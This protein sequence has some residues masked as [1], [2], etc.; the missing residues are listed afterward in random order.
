MEVMTEE[1]PRISTCG[2]T[3]NILILENEF[4][5]GGSEKKLFEFISRADREHYAIKVCC[6]KGGGYFKLP[7][8]AM[9]I[10]FYDQLLQHR[11]DLLAYRKLARIIRDEDIDLIY[12]F[13][14]ANTVLFSYLARVSGLVQAMV[15]S[16]HAMGNPEGGRLVPNYL[17]PFLDAADGYLAVA[18]RHKRYLVEVEGLDAAR[19][20]VIHNGVDTQKYRPGR[21]CD[22][23]RE[24]MQF[25]EGDTVITVV[26]SLKPAKCVDN[27][28]R[29]VA[30]N[31]ARFPRARVLVV[32]EGPEDGNLKSLAGSL[33]IGNHV[34][35]AGIRDDIDAVLRAT[36]LF[37]LPS[38]RGTETFPNVILE[39][40]ACGVPVVATDV[41][42]VT[43]LVAH[44]GSGLVIPPDDV[45]ALAAALAALLAD[46][47]KRS[48]YGTRG[49]EII[50]A[51][52]GIETMCEQ[53]E[54]VFARMLCGL[55]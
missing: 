16:F 5:M 41:G 30:Q 18:H 52:F 48:A 53:R 26:A 28:L 14:H 32:G 12:T 54:A 39:A 47:D 2:R 15:V 3:H 35:F 20:Q 51:Q 43:E 46:A 38:R 11:G 19:I 13:A 23:L 25:A 7:L 29:A 27:L 40:M 50:E 9:G 21:S 34:V 17:K 55:S 24:E 31:K 8:R 49:R 36:D 33:G 10:R 6:L 1:K 42:S 37:V 45:D 44:E 4:G 22:E